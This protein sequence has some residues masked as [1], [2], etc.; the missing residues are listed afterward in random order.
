MAAGLGKNGLVEKFATSIVGE[1]NDVRFAKL[2][3]S[4]QVSSS[5]ARAIP[6]INGPKTTPSPT[7]LEQQNCTDISYEQGDV[8]R[9]VTDDDFEFIQFA[10]VVSLD[11]PAGRM[12]QR[13]WELAH[14]LFDTHRDIPSSLSGSEK[15][16]YLLRLRKDKVSEFWK[17][18]VRNDV[19]LH[20]ARAGSVEEKAFAYLTGGL[21]EEACNALIEGK[22]FHLATLVAQIGCDKKF[23]ES[24]STQL[25]S[26]RALNN[27]AEFEDSI[28]AIYELLAGNTCVCEGQTAAGTENVT[29]TFSFATRFDL[30]WRRSFGLRLWYGIDPK[31]DVAEAVLKYLEDLKDG[32]EEVKPVPWFIEQKAATGWKDEAANTREDLLWSLLQLYGGDSFDLAAAFAPES[33]SGNPLDARLSFQLITLFQA[34]KVGVAADLG[35]ATID[36]LA[37]TYAADLAATIETRPIA[38]TSA[39]W[40]LLHLSDANARQS[41]VHALLDQHAALLE[42]RE[43]KI[44]AGLRDLRIPDKWMY[45]SKALYARA[46]LQ[47]P[48]AEA[49]NL[50]EAGEWAQAHDVVCRT[51]GPLAVIE[52]DSD[53]LRELLG[54]LHDPVRKG[55][56]N[57]YLD[58]WAKGAGIYYDFVEMRDLETQKGQRWK[59]LVAKLTRALERVSTEGGLEGKELRERAAIQ[60]MGNVVADYAA[61][62]QVLG[63]SEGLKVPLTEDKY[64]MHSRAL[65]L[66]YF[67]AL[68][69]DS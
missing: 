59:E 64:L 32:S 46:V 40:V 55:K 26:W 62:G 17:K 48:V 21:V 41:A 35:P 13:A 44:F 4:A 7:L 49:Q 51:V 67:K 29:A 14:I 12:E 8:P 58:A 37:S 19:Q 31:Q 28:R 5:Q 69:T 34:Q 33:V 47:D 25:E 2:S 52:N 10:E 66:E 53:Q 23:R 42:P 15:D 9:A 43:S 36:A 18:V 3:G 38:L 63:R 16:M 20:V 65:G 27:L 11:T 57:K 6:S 22:N 24:M 50:L 39:V 68:M 56:G 30:D 61:E 60:I 54:G 45:L 1:H